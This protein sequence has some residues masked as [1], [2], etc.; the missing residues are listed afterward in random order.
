MQVLDT[1]YSKQEIFPNWNLSI[2][3]DEPI[4][5]NAVDFSA[6][7]I[8]ENA[9]RDIQETLYLL[10]IPGMRDSLIDGRNTAIEECSSDLFIKLS[11]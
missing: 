6:I 5:L 3:P 4:K 11:N 1:E 8:S 10:A 7:M 9:W 2:L